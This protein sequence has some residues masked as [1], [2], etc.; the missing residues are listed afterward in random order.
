MASEYNFPVS[1]NETH[2]RNPRNR[3]SADQTVVMFPTPQS[4]V[5]DIV[6]FI[7]IH[8]VPNGVSIVVHTDAHDSYLIPPYVFVLDDHVLV[9]SH[10]F[11]ARSTPCGPNVNQKN[12][13]WLC[14]QFGS[15][16]AKNFVDLTKVGEWIAG[17]KLDFQFNINFGIIFLFDLLDDSFNFF[18]VLFF[19][20][21]WQIEAKALLAHFVDFSVSGFKDYHVDVLSRNCMVQ[22]N[23]LGLLDD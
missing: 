5:L 15:T 2:E 16:L 11:L 4:Q 22:I 9:V 1:I 13:A 7:L 6:P 20:L 14:C 3:E 17:S 23:L 8:S 12:L 21:S 18:D 10:R 19:C